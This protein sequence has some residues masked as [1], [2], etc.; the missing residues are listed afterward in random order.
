M[1]KVFSS[2]F[3]NV[4]VFENEDGSFS[5]VGQHDGMSIRQAIPTDEG[6][7]CILLLDPD[8][9]SCFVWICRASSATDKLT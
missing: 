5:S 2:S 8:A 9:S 3:P 6:K 4:V 1:N 7:N